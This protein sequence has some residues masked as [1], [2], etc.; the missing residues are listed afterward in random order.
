MSD[1]DVTMV[2]AWVGFD[3]DFLHVSGDEAM[4]ELDESTAMYC[5][6]A[7]NR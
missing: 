5:E 6:V 4:H 3:V 1:C 2:N 7:T